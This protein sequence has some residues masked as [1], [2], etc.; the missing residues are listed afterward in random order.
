MWSLRL[1]TP[2]PSR[3]LDGHGPTDHV[4][5]SEILRGRSVALHEAL[6]DGIGEI[7][8]LAP[9]AL[10]DQAARAVDPG[11]M[12]LHE[13][14]VLQRQPGAQHH[15]AA[16]TGA[17]VRG[18]ARKIGSPVPARSEDHDVGTKAMQR[19]FREIQRH[20]AAAR[21]V[22]HDQIDG[23]ELD[24]E[25]CLVPDRLLIKSVQHCVAGS[26][27]GRAGALRN[28]LA[29][30][31][32]HAAERTLIDVT[33]LGARKGDA[34][35]FQLDYCTRRFLAHEF[36][37][38]LIAEPVRPLDGVVHVPA[39]VVL[40]H[41]SQCGADAA[42]C[43]HRVAARRKNLGDAR[44]GQPG[45]RQP[46][47]RAQPGSAGADHHDVISVVDEAVRG[48]QEATPNVTRRIA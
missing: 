32:R 28:A 2:R 34:V 42:L 13:L 29:V 27:G 41:V 45:L 36:D 43:S 9:R 35:M 25:L 46:E 48:A 44:S 22:F 7:A 30:M 1:P 20:D 5:R 15:P 4:A 39:P 3:N 16:I 12:K 31:R 38:V 19:A 24:E 11:G 37:R 47:R 26:I 18:G 6:A 14:H 23:E 21:P 40:T 17:G 33:V 8:A 10:G